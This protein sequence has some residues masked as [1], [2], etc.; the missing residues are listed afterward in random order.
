MYKNYFLFFTLIF[1]FHHSILGQSNKL[2]LE[3]N[4][5]ALV[6]GSGMLVYGSGWL[7]R[8]RVKPF[9]ANQLAQLDMQQINALD[10]QTSFT[11]DGNLAKTSDYLL[12][13]SVAA[14]GFFLLPSHTRKEFGKIALLYGETYLL[15]AGLTTLTKSLVLRPRPYVYNEDIPA[16]DKLGRN[17]RFS[18]FSGHTSVTAANCFFFASVFSTYLPESKWKP[19]VWG[20]AAAVPGITAYLRVAAGRHFPT[21]VLVGYGLGAAIGVL[22]PK[23]HKSSKMRGLSI[24]PGPGSA[25]LSLRF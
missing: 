14:Q 6:L 22:I 9:T 19:V 8:N 5:E 11:L 17:A 21:D 12:L 2:V 4:K 10:R 1:S 15:V 20:L 24:L 13:S 7:A 18:F 16:M 25:Q 3:H 23:L